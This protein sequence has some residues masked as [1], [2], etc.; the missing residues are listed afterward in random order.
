MS[1]SKHTWIKRCSSIKETDPIGSF[2]CP[3]HKK[4]FLINTINKDGRGYG[5]YCS[6]CMKDRLKQSIDKFIK[7]VHERLPTHRGH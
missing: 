2:F 1:N 6:L 5:A 7:S 4:E 3:I